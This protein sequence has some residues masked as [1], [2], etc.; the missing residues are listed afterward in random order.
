MRPV[1]DF[2][3]CCWLDLCQLAASPELVIYLSGLCKRECRRLCVSGWERQIEGGRERW[4]K[5]RERGRKIRLR[6][7]IKIWYLCF[8]FLLILK[9]LFLL[10]IQLGN[11]NWIMC[12]DSEANWNSEWECLRA[13]K[14]VVWYNCVIG[15]LEVTQFLCVLVNTLIEGEWR[16][17]D[18]RGER[19]NGENRW[20]GVRESWF[21][22][23]SPDLIICSNLKYLMIMIMAFSQ[24]LFLNFN[25]FL[26][27][28]SAA[29]TNFIFYS[30]SLM[31]KLHMFNVDILHI[32]HP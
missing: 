20:R 3:G 18:W 29:I 22:Y 14:H 21:M 7:K 23:W 25:V 5:E 19:L 9:N 31:I 1:G 2:K 27:H 13:S 15:F 11:S 32:A 16:R 17:R 28:K 30:S 10:Y 12:H 6:E 24:S 8:C 4:I 26:L